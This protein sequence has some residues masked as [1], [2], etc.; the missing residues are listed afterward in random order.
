MD[1]YWGVCIN[2]RVPMLRAALVCIVIHCAISVAAAQDF[3]CVIAA[4]TPHIIPGYDND[5]DG[6]KPAVHKALMKCLTQYR[7]CLLLKGGRVVK[8][9]TPSEVQI[10]SRQVIFGLTQ[11][12]RGASRNYCTTGRLVSGE[13]DTF[14]WY[15]TFAPNGDGSIVEGLSDPTVAPKTSTELFDMLDKNFRYS[16]KELRRRVADEEFNLKELG[17]RDGEKP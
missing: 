8:A 4:K 2:V 1:A 15:S 12:H 11:M 6:K 13:G 3:P 7:V 5:E 10:N 16:I 14:W 9:Q 17:Y